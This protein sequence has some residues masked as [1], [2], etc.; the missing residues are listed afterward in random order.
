MTI[1]EAIVFLKSRGYTLEEEYIRNAAVY[2][3]GPVVDLDTASIILDSRFSPK[4]IM[5]IAVYV[6]SK[7]V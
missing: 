1:E 6:N 3:D 5:A 7:I 4:E 2:V